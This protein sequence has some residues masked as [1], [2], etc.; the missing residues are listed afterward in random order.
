[1][2]DASVLL[3]SDS[4]P[5]LAWMTSLQVRRFSVRG[6]L[7]VSVESDDASASVDHKN[8]FPFI[9]ITN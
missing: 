2:A 4:F 7:M 9:H 6:L 3:R 5:V 8:V 1:M